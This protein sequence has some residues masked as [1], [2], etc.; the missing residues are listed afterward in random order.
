MKKHKFRMDS[1]LKIKEFEEKNAWSEFLRQ[2]SRVLAIKKQINDLKEQQSM[3]R[4]KI[5][6]VGLKNGPELSEVS[7][8]N[9]SLSAT[10]QKIEVFYLSLANEEKTLER[11]RLKHVEAKK[12][13]KIIEKLKE[14]DISKY[15]ILRDKYDAK[16]TSEIGLQIYNRG[17]VENE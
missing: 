2:E 6:Q 17:K 11:L 1:F 14:N 10:K 3:A 7:W 15:K 16:V 5:S 4:K 12:E 9:E 13:L 8:T